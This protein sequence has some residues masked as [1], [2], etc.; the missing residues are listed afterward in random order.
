[1]ESSRWSLHGGIYYGHS[2]L[3]LLYLVVVHDAPDGYDYDDDLST[4][5]LDVVPIL[6]GESIDIT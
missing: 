4:N 2:T 6:C 5:T 1:M 3:S